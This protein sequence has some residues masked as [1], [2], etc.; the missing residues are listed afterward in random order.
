[1]GKYFNKA[2]I[3]NKYCGIRL[4]IF[5]GEHIFQKARRDLEIGQVLWKVV[6]IKIAKKY[7][8]KEINCD[9]TLNNKN[10]N[11]FGIW[12]DWYVVRELCI[13]SAGFW[14]YGETVDRW[15]TGHESDD[16]Q[17]VDRPL[18][19][20][21]DRQ[22]TG[23][24]SEEKV[25]QHTRKRC[26]PAKD[27]GFPW[28][29]WILQTHIKFQ[30]TVLYFFCGIDYQHCWFCPVSWSCKIQWLHL[31]REVTPLRVTWI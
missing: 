25:D 29:I 10:L 17:T 16:R 18:R 30:I 19:L 12:A 31:C 1:M 11:Y 24:A 23:F 15:L 21:A 28:S 13:H 3:L 9:P 27:P 22:Q 8:H 4:L 6:S 20:M 7:K 14:K 5:P 2:S 26:T